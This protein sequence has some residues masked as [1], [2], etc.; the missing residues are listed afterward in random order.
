MN[1]LMPAR[2]FLFLAITA[3]VLAAAPPAMGQ[4]LV[5]YSVE[6][7]PLPPEFH[8]STA[9]GI[10]DGDWDRPI[11][12]GTV[13]NA[14]CK[15]SCW[16]RA[17][18]GW[19]TYV[20]PGLDPNQNSHANAATEA[21]PGLGDWVMAVGMSMNSGAM[22]VPTAWRI[23]SGQNPVLIPL[24]VLNAGTGEARAIFRPDGTPVR[25][26]VCGYAD[27]FPPTAVAA[28]TAP[29]MGIRMPMI[30]EVSQTGERL[31][32]PEYGVGLSG[33]VNDIGSAG[34]DGFM[35]VG[36]GQNPTGGWGPQTWTS[37]DNG[38]TWQNEP[39]PLPMNM[40]TAEVTGF[41]YEELGKVVV[42][43][44]WG[45][46]SAPVTF[47]IV[48]EREAGNPTLPW[49]IHVLPLPSGADGGQ[50]GSVR[51]RPGRVKYS[52]TTTQSGMSQMTMWVDDGNGW[53]AL[54]PADYLQDPQI[55][56]PISPGALHG[57]FDAVATT[58]NTAT[59]GGGAFAPMQMD[60]VAALLV[61]TS[62]TSVQ[63]RTP[64]L[65]TLSA[66]PNPFNSALS[67]GYTLP[68]GARATVTVHDVRGAVVQQLEAVDV[69]AGE[70]REV[71]WNG[72][73]RD[74]RRAA[75]GVYFVRVATPHD[76]ATVKVVRIE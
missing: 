31:L 76:I 22:Q 66:S 61:S 64:R 52:S 40:V 13:E 12:V 11:I 36:G 21:P 19:T 70:A 5:E 23:P 54:L 20:L 17:A 49:T 69:A 10:A 35:A 28:D 7:M 6:L 56:T 65:I 14:P 62:P 55:G 57:K 71:R 9:R 8:A 73:M 29:Q 60:T 39:L 75:S 67:I 24:P 68:H 32:R 2:S 18:Q 47:P 4:G 41:D 53:T 45:Q 30:W 59:G 44:G 16:I 50:S 26:L 15:A 42:L 27:E 38:E 51:K 37:T 72:T 25:A 34:V 48:W 43:A 46:D 33:H 1:P 74:G 3:L 63:D 58:M